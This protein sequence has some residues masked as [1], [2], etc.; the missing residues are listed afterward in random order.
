MGDAELDFGKFDSKSARYKRRIIVFYDILGWRNKIKWAGS[1]FDRLTFLRDIVSLFNTTSV[2]INQHPKRIS[3]MTTFSD[4]VVISQDVGCDTDYFLFKIAY[5]QFSAAERG[6]W[7]RGG[8]TV[9][10]IIHDEN[11]VF[12]P[13]LNRA[14]ELE[15]REAVYPRIILDPQHLEILTIDADLIGTE[16]GITSL[17]PYSVRFF[18]KQE[19]LMGKKWLD[20]Y[21]EMTFF[22]NPTPEL[23]AIGKM[24]NIVEILDEELKSVVGE[25]E[26]EKLSWLSKHIQSSLA[27]S[28]PYEEVL[29]TMLPT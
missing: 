6:F 11:V 20:F 5:A 25:K 8:I 21:R 10:D 15:S 13:G 17:D 3:N 2:G 16:N 19:N 28:R 18:K 7:L 29:R 4:N 9:G 1:R 12:G 26:R 14:Y 23:I 27:N 24:R 22:L